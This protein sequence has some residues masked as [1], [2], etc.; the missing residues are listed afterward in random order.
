MAMHHPMPGRGMS[1]PE[2]SKRGIRG[3]LREL[4][5]Y[6][7]KLKVPMIIAL[8]LAAIGAFLTIVGPNQLWANDLTVMLFGVMFMLAS[9]WCLRDGGHV[10]TDFFY[11][12][13][14][15]RMKAV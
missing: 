11:H 4:F 6:S 1:A 10:R 15:V 12:N 2:K 7:S 14:S 8:T 5:T 3:V 13:W 9:P